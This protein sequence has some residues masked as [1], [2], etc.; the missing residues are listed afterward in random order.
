MAE[1]L[2]RPVFVPDRFREAVSGRAWLQAMLEAESALALAEAQAGL[3]PPDAAQAIASRCEAVRNAGLFDP[4]DLGRKGR[5]QGNPV[6]PLVKALT[7]AVSEVSEEA[8]RHVHKGATSQDIVDTAA[9][10]L[11]KRVLNLILTETDA[12]ATALA[13]LAEAH[14]DSPI[15]ARTL[16]QQALPTTFGL[17]VA[18]WLVSV[19]EARRR[20]L[21]VR[22]KELAVQLGGA[23]GT[24]ASLGDSGTEVLGAFA[25]ELELAEPAVPWHT[26]RYRIAEIGGAL[27]L[28]SGAL[29]KISLDIILMAQTEV[30]E[31]SE[32]AG[33]GRGGSSTLPH[34]RN[35]ILSVTAAASI[36]RVQHLSRTLQ[37]TMVQEHERAAGAWH[38][39]WEVLSEALALTGGAAVAVREATEGLEVHTEKM[40][41]N[42]DVTGGLLLTERLT[43]IV[44]GHFGRLKAHDLVEAVSRRTLKSGRS[45]REEI[46]AEPVLKEVLS[47]EDIDA[48]LDP[49]GYLGS[50]R[51]FVDRALEF[52]RE[53]VQQ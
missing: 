19:L 27:S 40:R 21:E 17:K 5:A 16:L 10:V 25:R 50:A 15:A 22:A 3:I 8:A 20:L 44:A 13:S 2:F 33:A 52:Y 28:L 39:E 12:I 41:E 29:G 37:E 43:T 6:P 34:K 1:E 53:E 14:C 42:L 26:D 47:E 11:T 51:V 31:V 4:E 35:P 23:G 36:R 30:G 45:L 18:G 38:S 9:M 48:A 49:A 32:P 7:D 46:L 24:L